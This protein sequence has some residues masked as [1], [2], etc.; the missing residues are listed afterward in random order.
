MTTAQKII[1]TKVGVFELAKQ[2]QSRQR[3]S[4]QKTL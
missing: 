1:T 3:V 4:I 2:L